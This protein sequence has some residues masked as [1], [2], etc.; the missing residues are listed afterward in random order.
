MFRTALYSGFHIALP[1]EPNL[2]AHWLLAD[3]PRKRP[4]SH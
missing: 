2:P 1:P 3:L 4:C